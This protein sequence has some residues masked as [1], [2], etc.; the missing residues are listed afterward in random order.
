MN[1]PV[2]KKCR[3]N[4]T[5]SKRLR[6]SYLSDNSEKEEK[7]PKKLRSHT[8][9]F[10][11]KRD[12]FIC[13]EIANY[14]KKHPERNAFTGFIHKITTIPFR[15]RIIQA[16]GKRTYS[17]AEEVKIR[18]HDCLDLIAVEAIYHHTCEL[19]FRLKESSDLAFKTPHG[20]PTDG[21]ALH[22]SV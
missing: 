20:R 14:D 22:H 1:P 21:S 19:K 6:L 12:C 4:Q 11:W 7:A 15:Q 17:W 18:L 9:D 3:R 16:C 2:H 13:G 8:S 10:E 5:D